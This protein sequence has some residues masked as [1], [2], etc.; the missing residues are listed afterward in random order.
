[1][2][3]QLSQ[4]CAVGLVELPSHPNSIHWQLHL[5]VHIQGPYSP[6]IPVSVSRL[7]FFLFQC[8]CRNLSSHHTSAALRLS[9][10][11]DTILLTHFHSLSQPFL[12]SP[13]HCFLPLAEALRQGSLNH[14]TCLSFREGK[15]NHEQ[16]SHPAKTRPSS[17][18]KKRLITSDA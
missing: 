18:T 10:G 12:L 2:I 8:A 11:A 4:S 5:L 15:R 9:P 3:S 16:N 13:L 7:L 17:N 14:H 1:M 6:F